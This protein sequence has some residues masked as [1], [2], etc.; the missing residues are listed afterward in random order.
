MKV[1]V[2]GG[3]PAGMMASIECARNGNEVI[4][5]EKNRTCGRKLSITGKGRCNITNNI[6]ISEFISNIPGN[7][8]FLYSAFSTYTNRDLINYINSLRSSYKSRKRRKSI[9]CV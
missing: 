2:I 8:K 9:S 3:G 7:G 1:V 5:I 6:D 4:L